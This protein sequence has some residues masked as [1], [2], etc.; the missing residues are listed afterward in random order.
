MPALRPYR[1]VVTRWKLSIVTRNQLSIWHVSI[2]IIA[3]R[4]SL[5]LCFGAATSPSFPI[6]LFV[7]LSFLAF[8]FALAPYIRFR[9][10]E[11]NAP[12]D[13]STESLSSSCWI[14]LGVWISLSFTTSSESGTVN[15]SLSE[16]QPASHLTFTHRERKFP[17]PHGGSSQLPT[18]YQSG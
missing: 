7:W 11:K 17:H 1:D 3:Y 16:G 4:T 10:E 15:K 14:P 9:T 6:F 2:G 5:P 8:P 12:E 18:L 13:F